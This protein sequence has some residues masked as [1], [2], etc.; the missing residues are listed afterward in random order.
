VHV[1]SPFAVATRILKL[2]LFV[3]LLVWLSWPIVEL[4]DTWDQPVDTGNDSQYTFVVLGICAGAVYVFSKRRQELLLVALVLV[5]RPI[6]R[7]VRVYRFTAPFVSL[8]S[9]MPDAP[10]PPIAPCSSVAILKI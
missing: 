3:V 8:L 5:T 4:F 7:V 6:G 1:S 10:S 2:A 9:W